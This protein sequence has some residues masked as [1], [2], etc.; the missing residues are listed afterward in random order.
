MVR[1][2]LADSGARVRLKQAHADADEAERL[3][4]RTLAEHGAGAPP[5]EIGLADV[6][7]RL[8][9]GQ[10]LLSFVAL[11]GRSDSVRIGAFVARG[12]M[13]QVGHVELGA[14]D[15]VWRAI[16]AWREALATPPTAD[17][18]RAERDAR[19]LGDAVRLRLWKPVAA[20]LGDAA[21]IFVV[22]DGPL[23]DLP[24]D[25]LPSGRHG[26]WAEDGPLIHPLDT[27]TSLMQPRG[28]PI[29]GR[30]VAVGAPDFERTTSP[31]S[32]G[33]PLAAALVR[34]EPD[35]CAETAAIHLAPL[36]G[37]GAEADSVAA[38]WRRGGAGPAT[39]LRG[40]DAGE[41][42]FK[43]EAPGCAVIHIA[44]HGVMRGDRCTESAAGT[45]GMGGIASVPPAN[46][47]ARRHRAGAPPAAPADPP[48][49]ADPS[50]WL[51]RRVWLAFAGANQAATE[52][53]SENDGYLTAEEVATL[54]LTGAD[55][56]VLSACHSGAGDAWSTD[57]R[58]GMRR[59]FARAGARSVIASAWALGDAT[60]GEWMTALYDARVHDGADAAASVH[61]AN[62]RV[63]AARRASRRST[64]P[65]YWA[66]FSS[67]DR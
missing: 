26:Y 1:G 61:A 51:S 45:R 67:S 50:P 23:A 24:W 15:D 21:E 37:S 18:A 2:V 64:H 20:A 4:A 35:P 62:R 38:A 57:G 9:P 13:P 31:V 41:A 32:E 48:A 10:A 55:W 34:T 8:A 59:A 63:L 65:F 52:A 53:T 54:D 22:A 39:L 12:G 33:P 25:A 27:E 47:A 58:L 19:T 56:V 6:R 7:A 3:Y 5:P 49:P 66:A 36:P 42:R 46:S 60:T 17:A 28:A 29:S 30:L 14:A 43:R 40:A 11:R 16:A 44:T